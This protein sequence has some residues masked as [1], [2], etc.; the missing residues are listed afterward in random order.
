MLK[1]VGDRNAPFKNK[2]K[3]MPDNSCLLR[4]KKK[5]HFDAPSMEST[6]K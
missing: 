3:W 2:E 4:Y 6:A 5:F 1:I